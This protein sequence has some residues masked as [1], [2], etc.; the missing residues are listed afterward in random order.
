MSKLLLVG[1][2]SKTDLSGKVPG[3]GQLMLRRALRSASHDAQVANFATSLSPRM[4]PP[5]IV[6]E[7]ADI[8]ARS[9]KPVVVEGKSLLA[10]FWKIPQFKNDMETL[11]KLSQQLTAIEQSVFQ[12]LGQELSTKIK[13]EGIDAVG[14]SLYLGSST[15]GSMI[16]SNIIRAENPTL[17]IF[18]GGPQTSHFASSIYRGTSAPTALVV[19]EGELSIIRLANIIGDLKAGNLNQL[20]DI[21]NLVFQN[22][23]GKIIATPRQRLSLQDWVAMSAGNY[24][25]Q[26]FKG[27]MK[28]AFIEAS[29]GCL[30]RCRFCPQPMLSGSDRYLKPAKNVVDEMIALYNKFGLTHFELVGSS[31]PPSQAEEIADEL[32]GRRLQGK[33]NWVLFMRGRDERAKTADPIELMKKL[34]SAGASSIFFGVEAADNETLKLMGKGEKIEDIKA[35]MIAARTA[36]IAT[37]GSFIYPYPGMPANEGKLIIDFLK[38]TRPLSAPSQALGLYPGTYVSDHAAEAGI[39]VVYP[40]Q[41]DQFLYQI[42]QKAQPTMQSPEVLDYLLQYPLILSLPMRFWPPLPYKIDGNNYQEYVKL[43]NKLQTE[44]AKLGILLGFSHSHYLISQ[45]LGLSPTDL[46]KEMF[47]CSLTGDPAATESLISRFN[48]KVNK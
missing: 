5:L 31:T 21:P 37:I 9:V 46:S 18:F 24:E 25:D 27:V 39:E 41:R 16:M 8:F 4:F 45:V 19:G 29:R 43:S 32:I 23:A 1:G 22:E 34:H 28:Y 44:I 30:Y 33:F 10:R 42:E 2:L 20:S 47:Y 38:E 11:K 26:D 7:L 40:I 15:T 36:G 14:F 12:Q 35:A 13:N 17:P 6:K 3:P 48:D